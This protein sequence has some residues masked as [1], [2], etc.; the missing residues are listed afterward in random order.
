ML[1]AWDGSTLRSGIIRRQPDL[2]DILHV[3]IISRRSHFQ[4]KQAVLIESERHECS[5]AVGVQNPSFVVVECTEY[6]RLCVFVGRRKCLFREQH[7]VDGN[8]VTLAVQNDADV[9]EVKFHPVRQ[10]LFHCD[11]HCVLLLA[12]CP[13]RTFNPIP[14]RPYSRYR[15]IITSLY[16]LSSV[17]SSRSGCSF[18]SQFQAYAMTDLKDADIIG[19]VRNYLKTTHR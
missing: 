1:Y 4:G 10:F 6:V 17:F 16:D 7:S 11:F 9:F 15:F 18:N 12:L 3:D 5:C 2:A 14:N 13:N 8:G 19:H